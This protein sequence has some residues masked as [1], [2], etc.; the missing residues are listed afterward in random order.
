MNRAPQPPRRQSSLDKREIRD[1]RDPRVPRDPR[2]PRDPRDP[3]VPRDPREDERRTGKRVYPFTNQAPL[4]IGEDLN[5]DKE[6]I[7]VCT[8]A[9]L[10]VM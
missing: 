9:E 4:A 1:P 10:F 5:Q 7:Q 3:R 2:N 6:L 8:L